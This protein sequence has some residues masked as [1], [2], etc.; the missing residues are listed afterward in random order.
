MCIMITNSNVTIWWRRFYIDLK[1]RPIQAFLWNQLLQCRG[2]FIDDHPKFWNFHI[3]E[4]NY[5][6]NRILNLIPQG[7]PLPCLMIFHEHTF[8]TVSYCMYGFG[9]CTLNSELTPD[10]LVYN[11]NISN[12]Y[13]FQYYMWH[14]QGYYGICMNITHFKI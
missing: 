3:M 9:C 2:I 1:S 13:R 10:N 11:I 4:V 7:E 14:F 8:N 12:G 5:Q 6:V